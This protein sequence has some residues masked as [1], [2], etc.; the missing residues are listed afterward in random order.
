MDIQQAL[1]LYREAGRVVLPIPL[2]SKRT[3]VSDWSNPS[4]QQFEVGPD[5]NIAWRLDDLIDVDLDCTEARAMASILLPTTFARSGRPSAGIPSHWFYSAADAEYQ[6]F[7]DP[8]SGV[9]LEL[10][11]SHKFYTM[12][13]PSLMPTSR[14]GF[15]TERL[16]WF[17]HNGSIGTSAPPK[18]E[19]PTLQ[20]ACVLLAVA[21]LLV[22]GLGRYGFG[23]EARLEVAGFLL[24]QNC[25]EDEVIQICRAVSGPT[26][27]AEFDDIVPVVRTTAAKLTA[28]SKKVAGG[29]KLAERMG[30]SGKAR[31]MAI[32]KWLVSDSDVNMPEGMFPLTEAGDAEHFA[33]LNA[34]IV[35]YNWRI[36]DWLYF[37]GQ[38]WVMQAGG[39]LDRLTLESMR[40]RLKS[41]AAE[42]AD[43][44]VRDPA[45]K[46]AMTGESWVRRS[47]LL[48]SARSVVPLADEGREWN[49]DLDPWLLGTPSGV[50]DLRTGEVRN[51]RP[52]DRIT[53]R[54]RATWEPDAKCPTWDRTINEVF[55][56]DEA[57]IGFFDRFVGYSITGDCREEALVVC[58]GDGANGKGTLM[59]T[60][61]WMLGDY[62]D[63]LP[64]STFEKRPEH[65]GESG[66]SNDIAKIVGKRFVMSSETDKMARLNE[67]K[68]K[69]LTGRDPVTA[70]FLYKEYF[71][72][73]PMAKFWLATNYKPSVQDDS[74][75]FWRRI[76]LL[77]FTQSFI[78]REDKKRKHKLYEELP[79]ILARAVRG[80]QQWIERGL[81]SPKMVTAATSDWQKQSDVL[82]PFLE[83]CCVIANDA[84]VQSKQLYHA[85]LR[86]TQH[87]REKPMP[88]QIFYSRIDKVYGKEVAGRN[89]IYH[90]IGLPDGH[91]EDTQWPL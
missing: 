25:T 52:E 50:V 90:G 86:W 33:R 57:L 5:D 28:N 61:A 24:R 80:T 9:L 72:F 8:M 37:D 20:R 58:Y 27:N 62:A 12:V 46:W 38:G 40:D 48:Q 69:Q 44:K 15:P 74:N 54:T 88:P 49:W 67:A 39:Q 26:E 30:E 85:Y 36:G 3:A 87:T 23:H 10:R 79:G 64:F 43:P 55:D 11:A 71:T 89:T 2:G 17:G 14:D 18:V 60:I 32:A 75:A 56:G 82:G 45:L 1:A 63:N 13:P 4:R 65:I 91:G 51:G 77:P 34:R 21:C 68:I 83:E 78:G 66:Q 29:P 19:G 84:H 70:R 7:E 47:H 53:Y 22:R 6:K 76:L 42:I 41:A 16:A 73:I 81:D 59:N 31:V 35:R